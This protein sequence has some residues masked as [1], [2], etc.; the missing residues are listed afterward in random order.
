MAAGV[1]LIFLIPFCAENK[2]EE[3]DIDEILITDQEK[4][5]DNNS[6]EKLETIRESASSI[7]KKTILL[8]KD[9]GRAVSN[10]PKR[11]SRLCLIPCLPPHG[12]LGVEEGS[13]CQEDDA[14]DTPDVEKISAL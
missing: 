10:M 1:M 8:P 12:H 11:K 14:G 7:D 3:I 2:D 4:P 9:S 5:S 13:D 6:N